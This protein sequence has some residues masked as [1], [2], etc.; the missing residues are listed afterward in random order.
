MWLGP[1]VDKTALA[2]EKFIGECCNAV[3]KLW[4]LGNEHML[5][6]MLSTTNVVVFVVLACSIF[7]KASQL[8]KISI[9]I[10]ISVKRVCSMF[11]HCPTDLLTM[12]ECDCFIL[13][14]T[15][16]LDSLDF[17]FLFF[18]TSAIRDWCS[19]FLMLLA[20][21]DLA[22]K[23]IY[24]TLWWVNYYSN[25]N[26]M[27][28]CTESCLTLGLCSNSLLLTETLGGYLGMACSQMTPTLLALPGLTLP[29]KRSRQHVC[30]TWR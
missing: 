10:Q 13:K 17:G 28:S 21:G 5:T 3:I 23:K 27:Q 22:K 4:K 20:Q 12:H 19:L 29:W 7:S 8:F 16:S 15:C 2:V 24:P 1:R 14:L 6:E 9:K 25:A 18:S 30:L 26:C 11:S